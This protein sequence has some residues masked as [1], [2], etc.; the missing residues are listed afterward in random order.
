MKIRLKKT[1]VEKSS[2]SEDDC[3][4]LNSVFNFILN[5]C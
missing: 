3:K 2:E 1:P 5:Q 4:S